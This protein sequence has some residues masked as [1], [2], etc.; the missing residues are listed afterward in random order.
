MSENILKVYTGL[1]SRMRQNPCP[2]YYNLALNST[3]NLLY[4]Y[5]QNQLKLDAVAYT[6]VVLACKGPRQRT[7][8][9]V[10]LGYYTEKQTQLL[11]HLTTTYGC[12]K[13]V[14]LGNLGLYDYLR[15]SKEQDQLASIL[16]GVILP[17][18]G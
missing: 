4:L 11:I 12:Q 3:S 10:S 14:R 15:L 18:S 17:S 1:K 9:E 6:S 8:S 16:L 2:Q 13:S 5:T 7:E